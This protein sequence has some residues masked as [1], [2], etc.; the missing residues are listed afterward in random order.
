MKDLVLI[1]TGTEDGK[2]KSK[3]FTVGVAKNR[4]FQNFDIE[5]PKEVYA[6]E[7]KKLFTW[8]NGTLAPFT[9]VMSI[10]K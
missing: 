4:D 8:E 6:W 9:A 3:I 2:F 1:V 7:N 5:I 10:Y